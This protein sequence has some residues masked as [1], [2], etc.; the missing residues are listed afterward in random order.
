MHLIALLEVL[1]IRIFVVSGKHV[2]V[3]FQIPAHVFI[4]DRK[5]KEELLIDAFLLN[6][7][8][9]HTQR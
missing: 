2:N 6:K 3:L 5:Q 9:A 4:H 7:T 1:I 8:H